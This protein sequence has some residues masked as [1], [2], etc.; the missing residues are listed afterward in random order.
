MPAHFQEQTSKEYF[1]GLAIIHIALLIGLLAFALVMYFTL[2][3]DELPKVEDSLNDI[4]QYLTPGLALIATFLSF[5]RYNKGTANLI[6]ENKL[7]LK[8]GQ[9]KLLYISHLAL[10]EFAG[11]FANISFFTT[12]VNWYLGITLIM[13][14]LMWIVRPTKE[15][16]ALDLQLN[17]K[18]K[19]LIDDPDAIVAV[20]RVGN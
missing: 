5:K 17:H 11:L 14:V 18:E 3:N 10:F 20:V 4:F 19:M 13:M 7:E 6:S 15:K 9:Y 2:M 1:R 12:G 8:L 16:I